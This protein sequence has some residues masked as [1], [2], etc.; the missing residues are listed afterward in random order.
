MVHLRRCSEGGKV[1]EKEK[2]K[3]K[4]DNVLGPTL[5]FLSKWHQRKKECPGEG[6]GKEKKK[7]QLIII[8]RKMLEAKKDTRKRKKGEGGHVYHAVSVGEKKGVAKIKKRRER[9][10]LFLS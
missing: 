5:T 7:T 3:K 9:A 2:K 4:M 1:K 10:S 8:T 6:R